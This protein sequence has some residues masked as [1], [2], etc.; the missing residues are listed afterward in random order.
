MNLDITIF[1]G[2]LLVNIILGLYSSRGIKNIRE[3]AIGNRNFSTVTIAAT[4]VA[5]WIAGS[6]FSI[7]VSET[8]NQGLYF[9]IPGL[10]DCVSIFLITYFIIP[11]TGEFLGDLSVADSMG[12]L[13]GNKVRAISSIS[14]LLPAICNVSL[15][16]TVLTSIL[17]YFLKI[18]AI[19][20]V[21]ASSSI[22]IIYSTLGGIKAVTF[23]DIV[24]SAAFG[25]IIPII[26]LLI[27]KTIDSQSISENLVDN[28]L[29]DLSRVFDFN[30]PKFSSTAL[31]FLFLLIPSLDPALYQRITMSKDVNQ[32]SG[33]FYLSG[34]FITLCTASLMA[35]GVLLIAAGKT[36][37]ILNQDN[38][39]SFISD[40]YLGIGF[41][42]LFLIGITA[43]IM[44]TA[45]SYINSASVLIAHDLFGS[46]KITMS[47]KQRLFSVR[48]IAFFIGVGA[49]LISLYFQ[50]LLGLMLVSY[51]FYMPVVS[52]IMLS[53]IFGF[54]SNSTSA[55]I[56]MT[57]GF[58]TV[59]SLK[60]FTDIDSLLPGMAANFTCFMLSHYLL[61]AQGGWVGIKDTT[62]L[63]LIK[64]K[65]KQVIMSLVD[66]LKNFS[67]TKFFRDNLP[68]DNSIYVFYGFFCLI[69]T[70]AAVYSIPSHIY[71]ICP[72]IIDRSYYLTL[73]ITTIFITY[74]AWS[75]RFKNT[76]LIAILWTFSIFFNLIFV[77]SFLVIL[78]KF[79]RI[80]L[81]VLMSDL[82]TVAV[83]LRWQVTLWL[84]PVGIFL[85]TVSYKLA[86]GNIP[87]NTNDFK[88]NLVYVSLFLGTIL[89]A[90]LR[91]KQEYIKIT[92]AK[93]G[94]LEGEVGSLNHKID[95]L[96]EVVTH[97][98]ERVQN[99]QQEIDR[100]GAA[101]QKILNNVNHEL[102]LP[103][104]NVMNF[105]EMLKESLTKK[106]DKY[107]REL[108]DEV[109]NNSV[110]LSTMILNM[111]DLAML[112]VKKIE[113]KKE[114][115]DF[116]KLIVG[117]I[118]NCRKVYLQGKP[119]EFELD[120]EPNIY[121]EIDPNYVRQVVDNLV[122]NA[123]TYSNDG[124]IKI[125]ASKKTKNIIELTIQDQ[126]IGIPKS[127]IYD[128][129]TPFKTG[130]K[131]ESKVKGA[132]WD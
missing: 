29:F 93:I 110:R 90:F 33:A 88:Q 78:N 73:I 39:I 6:S 81:I 122:I 51:S 118:D 26:A 31:L 28:P 120:I 123:I 113:L 114:K 9:I 58:A 66:G 35:I 84:T 32:A 43:M 92:E 111:L 68:I 8:Y 91:P 108:A 131:T 27:W 116:S 104:G 2:F 61:K 48:C 44:S 4:L 65:R 11:R 97:Y 64:N 129:F 46:L 115:T 62:S 96:H 18:P 13:Y 7:T 37:L 126:G 125:K 105:A 36:D 34:I 14:A 112:D 38:V 102:R 22:V 56:G 124:V 82:I 47:E 94:G 107:V 15:Q 86:I 121:L 80:H 49:L 70:I 3:Y 87:S 30:N 89:I 10:A 12:K 103:V 132:A 42:G 95:D 98:D 24:Q 99:Q 59:V 127:E 119:I 20:A 77:G 130:S 17:S 54:R 76:N 67:I 21:L 75:I 52:V 50:N 41:K 45:D 25:I 100:L 83:L 101:A 60:L 16:F 1:T 117:R 63:D 19:Y 79:D 71:N 5:T 128:I 69:S 53:A 106:G 57:A 55:L 72:N 85:S 40:S 23:T 109:H 74:P